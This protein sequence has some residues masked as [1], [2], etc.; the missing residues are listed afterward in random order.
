MRRIAGVLVR[1]RST[2][3]A[4]LAVPSFLATWSAILLVW[5][6]CGTW[7]LSTDVGRQATVDERVRVTEALGGRVTDEQYEALQESPPL[8]TYLTSGGRVLLLP[9]VTLLAALGVLVMARRHGSRM[10]VAA[11]LA[12]SV[13]AAVVLALQQVVAT[14]LHYLRE[15]LT[16]PANLALVLP[17]VEDGS[18]AAGFLGA[19]ELFGLWWVWLLAV[20][21]SAATGRPARGYVLRF[22]AAYAGVALIVAVALAIAGGS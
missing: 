5:M 22:A 16:S 15:S 8:L 21:V 7:L 6:A 9:P 20:G 19:I 3:A 17:G 13:H 2:M 12:V 10:G 18:L 14:P 4:L 11:A 1:P